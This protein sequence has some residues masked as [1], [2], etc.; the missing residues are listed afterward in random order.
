MT[1]AIF[2]DRDGVIIENRA[3][4]VRSWADVVFLAQALDALRRASS[5]NHKVVIVTNQS[6]VGRGLIAP[7]TADYI[8]GRIIGE[9]HEAGGRIDAVYMCPHA[10]ADHCG[11]RKPAPG[12][13]LAAA[14]DMDIDLT[15]SV[16][17]GDALS[18]LE[19]G[20]RAGVGQV[21]LVRSG[22]GAAQAALPSAKRL[23]PFAIYDDLADALA[24]L[25][26][27]G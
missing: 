19:A 13:L 25:F 22:R 1:P 11:C 18:D 27:A 14:H 7:E 10:P 12:L 15:R 17:I 2:L 8:N 21:A 24:A 6:G 16:L 23:P 20:L 9:I 4:Y 5:L 3:S 26:P